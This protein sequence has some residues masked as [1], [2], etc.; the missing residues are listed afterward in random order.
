M[1]AVDHAPR[2]QAYAAGKSGERLRIAVIPERYGRVISPCASIRL[3][4]F[5]ESFKAAAHADVRYVLPSEISRFSPNLIVWHRASISHAEDVLAMREIAT[6]N[7]SRLIYDID[8]NLL[9]MEGHGE[10]AS[11]Q[12]VTEAVRASLQVADEIWCSTPNLVQR[13]GI[14]TTVQPMLM[15]NVL[16]PDLWALGGD[17]PDA[18]KVTGRPLQLLYMGTR[19]HDSDFGL[20]H[21]ALEQLERRY[22]GRFRL[23]VIGVRSDDSVRATWLHTLTPPPGVGASYP[24]FVH[25]FRGMQGFDAGLAPL[26]SN[27]FNVC[28]SPIKILDYAAIG[29]PTLASNVPAYTHSFTNGLD[30][31]H[32][33]NAAESWASALIGLLEAPTRLSAIT[34]R[35]RQS[36]DPVRFMEATEARWNRI[37]HRVG[38]Q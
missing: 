7:G 17:A 13:A 15:P 38:T 21:E 11:Y 33:E 25:W 27:R 2:L 37:A 18:G 1:H 23:S 9:D 6:R 16:D 22:P 14:E 35:A 32:V 31:V 30:C 34:A 28:K 3:H 29:L 8:D 26:V 36:V 12:G 20:V 19:T 24:A 4:P 10:Q 5:F